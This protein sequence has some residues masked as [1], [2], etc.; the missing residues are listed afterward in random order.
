[1]FGK[2]KPNSVSIRGGQRRSSPRK[3]HY[4]SNKVTPESTESCD[5]I[6]TNPKPKFNLRVSSISRGKE[7]SHRRGPNMKKQNGSGGSCQR[8]YAGAFKTN[9]AK[10]AKK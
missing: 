8:Q 6:V 2:K 4:T 5:T 3:G 9:R 7:V 10:N 1:M